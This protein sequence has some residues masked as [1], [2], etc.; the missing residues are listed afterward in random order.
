MKEERKTPE[1][2]ATITDIERRRHS[3]S[4]VL[5]FCHVER[6]RDISY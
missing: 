3:P 5:A 1:Q 4:R 2:R 6:S